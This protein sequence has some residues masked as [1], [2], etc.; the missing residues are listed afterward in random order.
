MC[1]RDRLEMEN[2]VLLPHI[3]SATRQTRDKMSALT[4]RNILAVLS[5]E[6]AETP[7]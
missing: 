2:V 3:G 5:G 6:K 7:L 1:I 4:A